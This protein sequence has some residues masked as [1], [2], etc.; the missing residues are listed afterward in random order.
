MI[1]RLFCKDLWGTHGQNRES[2]R[3]PT[4][5]E[6]RYLSMAVDGQPSCS[7][8]AELGGSPATQVASSVSTSE[9]LNLPLATTMYPTER[10]VYNLCVE[11]GNAQRRSLNQ[12][13]VT[14]RY[15]GAAGGAAEA[16][17]TAG[18]LLGLAHSLGLGGGGL[19]GLQQSQ[20]MYEAQQKLEVGAAVAG[21][22]TG[23][24]GLNPVQQAALAEIEQGVAREFQAGGRGM[25]K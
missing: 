4:T 14:L 15:G 17:E 11:R 23:G 9:S 8:L 24:A 16:A 10:Q 7:L 5:R 6:R 22:A 2:M 12:P 13:E 20:K 1:Q 25:L 3:W 19:S 21:Q 18:A